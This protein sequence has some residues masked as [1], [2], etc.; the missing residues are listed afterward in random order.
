ME[1]AG[2]I[3]STAGHPSSRLILIGM[4]G[5]GKSTVARRVAGQLSWVW[6]DT[7]AC[8]E[9]I[10]MLSI[11]EIFSRHGEEEF[12]KRDWECV[13]QAVKTRFAVISCGGGAP[14]FFNAIDLLLKSGT[15]I[16]LH[17]SPHVLYERL[18]KDNTDRPLLMQQ[19]KA[20]EQLLEET[21]RQREP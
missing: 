11:A 12:R 16:Y 14:C 9:Q 13:R 1:Q 19:G 5:A 18:R 7:D 20:T 15:V 10:S 6:M 21:L 3:P 4:P 17:A 2:R 8:V